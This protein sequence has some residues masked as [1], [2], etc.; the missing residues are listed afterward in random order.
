MILTQE[1]LRQQSYQRN[2]DI[3]SQREIINENTNI[4]SKKGKYDL[5]ISHSFLDKELILTLVKLFNENS[6]SVYVDWIHDSS[7]DRTN[8]TS[9]TAKIIRDRI[10][11]C[12]GLAYISTSNI[13]NSKWCPW[14]LGLGDGLNK[15]RSCILPVMEKGDSFKGTEYIGIYPYI[16]Y[17]KIQG[18]NSYDFWVIDPDDPSK[19][20]SLRSWLDGN[21]LKK[22]I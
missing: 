13:I 8:V 12:K 15:G 19:Y 7:L 20:I 11:Q 9:K 5:F 18:K 2:I 6:Y 3:Y 10:V 4:F 14:E 16:E 1:Y 21:N 22:H 17:E